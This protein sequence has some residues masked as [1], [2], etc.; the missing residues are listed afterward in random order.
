MLLGAAMGGDL[1]QKYTVYPLI[2]CILGI[3]ASLI[4]IQFVRVGKNGKPGNA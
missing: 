1:G 4:G 2:L 3:F